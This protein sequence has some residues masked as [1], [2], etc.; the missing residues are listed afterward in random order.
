MLKIIR[1]REQAKLQCLQDSRE[2]NGDNLN[3]VTREANT[4][5]KNKKMQY[6]KDRINELATNSKHK[7]IRDLYT[8]INTLKMATIL[9]IT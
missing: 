6:M 5:F 3:N 1:S 2:I 9:E 8:G 4:H 7:N